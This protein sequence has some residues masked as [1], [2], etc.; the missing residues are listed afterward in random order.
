[1][2][3]RGGPTFVDLP[4]DVLLSR[5]AEEEG[6]PARMPVELGEAYPDPD[7]VRIAAT[8]LARAK[9]P[10]VL[11]GTMAYWNRAE[12]ALAEFARVYR[13]PI[14]MNG[15]ARGLL[16]CRHPYVCFSGRRKALAD[17]DLVLAL[18]FD[19]DFRLEFGQ[20]INPAADIIQVDPDRA[21][22]GRNRAISLGIA[23]SVRAFLL[24]LL[25]QVG[26]FGRLEEREHLVEMKSQD[27]AMR[28]QQ[29]AMTECGRQSP[30][31]PLRLC[32][33]V[34]SYLDEDAV[35]IGDGG[36]IVSLFASVYHAS[37]PGH[38][39]DPG[40]FGC[41]GVGAPFAIGA[42]LARP[43]KQVAVMFGDGS[44]G[45]NGFE[46]DSAVRQKLP[47]V[48]IVGNDGAWGEMR[49]F[50]QD[51]FGSSDTSAQ[52]LSQE[53]RYDKVVEALGGFGRT[54]EDAGDIKPALREAFNAQMPALVNVILDPQYRRLNDSI[55]GRHVAAAYGGGDQDAFRR[56]Q[57]NI[58]FSK[59]P[60]Y[61]A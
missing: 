55:S 56:D 8:L 14:Y 28:E 7:Q 10:V 15:M 49:N 5:C 39:M 21:S 23:C 60:L 37:R 43:D 58:D 35:V 61:P 40:P 27:R 47:F 20:S 19:F 18:G 25:D 57:S 9:R 34:T 26:L 52:H 51:L 24:S 17:A 11:A 6:P 54:V 50:H 42:R 45:F 30:V 53:T 1:M 4:M 16:P 2:S 46:Y 22:I 3:S 38:W 48:G 31:H 33:E 36:D 41:L 59:F 32:A 44:F 29:H 13:A 12:E